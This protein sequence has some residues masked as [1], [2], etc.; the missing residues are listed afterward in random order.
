[1][2]KDAR[3]WYQPIIAYAHEIDELGVTYIIHDAEVLPAEPETDI[4]PPLAAQVEFGKVWVRG[5][6]RETAITVSAD[7]Q[8]AIEE[9][10]LWRAQTD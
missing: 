7:L 1:M 10:I 6:L 9:H 8:R 4:D 3:S 2:K 5:D